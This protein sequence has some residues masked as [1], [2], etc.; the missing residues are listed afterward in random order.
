MANEKIFQSRIQLKHDIEENWS[1]ATNFIPKV[2]EIIIYDIDEN[3]SIARFK[4]GD[5]ITNINSL[6]FV[7]H[8]EVISYLPQELTEEQKKQARDNIGSGDPQIQG[9]WNQNDETAVDFIKNR[10]HY[11]TPEVTTNLLNDD[12][13]LKLYPWKLDKAYTLRVDGVDYRVDGFINGGYMSVI[14]QDIW[15]LGAATGFDGTTVTVMSWDEYPFS[16]HGPQS[17]ITNGSESLTIKYAD[18]TTDHTIEIIEKEKNIKYLDPKY[19]KDMYFE[20]KTTIFDEQTINGF[21]VIKD[22]LYAVNM[23]NVF[24]PEEGKECTVEWDGVAYDV[25]WEI[26]PKA[27]I[28]YAGNENYANMTSG[29]DIPFAILVSPTENLMGFITESTAESHTVCVKELGIHYIDPKYIKDMYYDNGIAITEVMP[30]TTV[31]IGQDFPT[32][33]NLSNI[34]VGNTYIVT[35]NGELYECICYQFEGVKVIGNTDAFGGAGG[36]DEPFCIVNLG[37]VTR[38]MALEAG[39]YTIS[40]TEYAHDIKQLDTKYLPIIKEDKKVVF[41][42]NDV[43]N[44][45]EYRDESFK[46]LLGKYSITVD[47]KLYTLFF[48]A[49]K[50]FSLAENEIIYIETW[51][52]GIYISFADGE[53]HSVKIKKIIEVIDDKYLPQ[54]DWNQND[55]TAPGYI[56]NRT[57]YKYIVNETIYETLEFTA[58]SESQLSRTLIAGDMDAAYEH[59]EQITKIK[60]NENDYNATLTFDRGWFSINSDVLT[61]SGRYNSGE[62]F[63]INSKDTSVLS[64]VVGQTYMVSYASD[65][66]TVVYQKI[67]ANYVPIGTDFVI[68]DGVIRSNVGQKFGSASMRSGE[69]FNDTVDNEATGQF[70]HAEGSNTTASGESSHAEGHNTIASGEK[71]H[72]EGL[73]T[74]ASG[75]YSHAEGCGTTASGHY[76]HAEGSYTKASDEYQHVQGKYNID[77]PDSVYQHIVGNGT[78]DIL[79]NAHTLDWSGNAWYSGDVYVGSTSGTNKDEGSKKLATEEYVDNANNI[80]IAEYGVTTGE[81]LEEAYNAGKTIFCKD[82]AKL[83][84]LTG[85]DYGDYTFVGGAQNTRYIARYFSFLRIWHSETQT[86]SFEGHEHE[87]GEIMY[88]G[89]PISAKVDEL[90]SNMSQ[91]IGDIGGMNTMI[92]IKTETIDNWIL[93]EGYFGSTYISTGG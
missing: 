81:E 4:I 69:V 9:D 79:S 68:E 55:E 3:N 78:S 53:T 31:K 2:G 28:I 48:N 75:Y 90:D 89:T 88:N 36:N 74:T 35:W 38:V 29:G 92:N 16:I 50:D 61:C 26:H 62:E 91:L 45:T 18:G 52:G 17:Y 54:S 11:E 44:D 72:A 71:S 60:I 77:D 7:S 83:L 56:A 15:Y 66:E 5:G 33:L 32:E 8:H 49:I 67:D 93:T 65:E 25:V 87:S 21:A 82:G 86:L 84:T 34:T 23:E 30:E 19:I 76:S 42:M 41:E 46:T 22:S 59:I 27:P 10:T 20:D 70:S 1:K 64:F 47:D 14:G 43:E 13:T 73:N 24:A 57:H 40:I 12:G 58:I 39:T 80:F 51:N 6:P 63:V 85:Y 37:G